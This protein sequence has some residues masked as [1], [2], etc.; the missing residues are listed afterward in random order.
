[1]LLHD[2]K[3]RRWTAAAAWNSLCNIST[4]GMQ[5]VYHIAH[6][7]RKPRQKRTRL[8]SNQLRRKNQPDPGITLVRLLPRQQ[9]NSTQ[10]RLHTQSVWTG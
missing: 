3:L 10:A 8:G 7:R 9:S 6:P 4:Q 5:N 2:E 1:M